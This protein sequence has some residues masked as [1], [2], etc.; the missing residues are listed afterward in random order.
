MEDLL[1]KLVV[2]MADHGPEGIAFGTL[3]F[4]IGVLSVTLYKSFS[5]RLETGTVV[6]TALLE[7]AKSQDR[8]TD[9][10]QET[11]RTRDALV[12]AL[13]AN[14]FEIKALAFA[15]SALEATIAHE[16][17]MNRSHMA[18]LAKAMDN[19]QYQRPRG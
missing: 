8:I 14:G 16:G 4:C 13:G 15:I 12:A 11:N 1:S 3:F 7:A 5:A 17:E 18:N 19:L 10:F 2:M 6:T 9:Q